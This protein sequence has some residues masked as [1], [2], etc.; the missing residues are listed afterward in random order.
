[1]HRERRTH[2]RPKTQGCNEQ[3][4]T[5]ERL[6]PAERAAGE[7]CGLSPPRRRSGPGLQPG[8][9]WCPRGAAGPTHQKETSGPTAEAPGPSRPGG[10]GP[11]APPRGHVASRGPA[12]G[13][14][15]RL[16]PAGSAPV[17]PAPPTPTPPPPPSWARASPRR[18]RG[19]GGGQGSRLPRRV[20]RLRS[21][22]AGSKPCLVAGELDNRVPSLALPCKAQRLP[23][24]ERG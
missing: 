7:A 13:R 23:L 14:L 1:M 16:R 6:P 21:W 20:E 18:V 11:L 9:S 22:P 5:L 2:K 15:L 4:S 8:T 3:S 10:A 12:Q 19:D 17:G 24:W